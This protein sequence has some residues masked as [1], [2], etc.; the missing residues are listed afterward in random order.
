MKARFFALAALV[1]GLASCQQEFNGAA[2]VGGEVDFQ[3]SVAAPELG[4]TRATDLDGDEFNGHNS[5]YGAI[6]YLENDWDKVD[7]RY[8]L[9]VF[10]AKADYSSNEVSPVKDRQ[11]I[12]VDKY[13]PVT[14]D[15]RLVP[16]REYRFVVFADFVDQGASNDP[17]FTTQNE[18]GLHYNLGYDLRTIT[19]KEDKDAINQEYTDA[20]FDF[21]EFTI[22]NSAAKDMVLTRP[23]GKVRVIATDLNQL[24]INVDPG[25][26]VV[27]Y[28]EA[29]VS[30]F[31]AVTGD[32]DKEQRLN[33]VVYE[34]VYAEKATK[35]NLSAHYYNAGYDA[36]KAANANGVERH[37]H[38]TLFTDYILAEDN[39]HTIHFTMEVFDKAGT[40]IKKT[41]FNTDIP[42]QRNNLT[43]IVGNVLTTATEINVTINDNFDGNHNVALYDWKGEIKE[44]EFV[45][46]AYEIY[47][48]SELAWLAKAVNEGNTFAGKTVNLCKDI[49]L[50]DDPWT[51]IGFTGSF[52][53]TFDGQGHK[54]AH[55]FVCRPGK[56][57]VGLFGTTKNGEIKDLVVECAYVKGRLN[58]GVVAGNPYTSKFTDITVCGDVK[59]EGMAYVGGVGGKNAYA[60][61]TNVTVNANAGSYVKANSVENGTAYR[62]YVGGVLGFNGEGGHKFENISSNI[63]VE[64]TTCDV[65]GLFGIAHYDNKFVNCSCSGNVEITAAD[66]SADAQE[67]GGIAGVWHNAT[68]HTVTLDGCEFT[69]TLKTNKDV[70]YYYRGLIGKP[71]NTTGLGKLIVDGVHYV[72]A[73]N[74]LADILKNFDGRKILFGYDIN[75][76]VTV[77]QNEGQN[78]VINGDYDKAN[79]YNYSF[80]GTFEVVGNNRNTGAETLTF[81]NIKFETS[82]DGVYFINSNSQD[83]PGRYSHNITVKNCTFKG[84]SDYT[85][86]GARLR[87]AY[88]IKFE[89]CEVQR[90]HSLL[91]AYGISGVTIDNV[92]IKNSKNGISFGS[93][94]DAVLSNSTIKVNEYGVR[95]D[96]NGQRE[97]KLENVNIDAFKPVIVR[98]ATAHYTVTLTGN[99]TL[100]A[101]G[102]D[103][104]FTTGSDD[105]ALAAPS[106]YTLNGGDTFKVF[107]RDEEAYGYVYMNADFSNRLAANKALV[108]LVPG[109]FDGTFALK[110][111]MTIVGTEGAVA[112]CFNLN[113]ADNVTIKNVTFDAAKATMGYDGSSKAKQ[114]ANIITG[115]KTN[116]PIKGAWNLVIKDCKFT[117]TFANGGASIAFTDQSRSSGGSGN[118]TIEGCTFETEGGYC[119]I[120]GHYCGNGNNGY[121]DFVIEGNTFNTEFTQGSP[122]YLGRYA[123][124]TP[125]V[126]KGN[127]FNT[128]DSLAN[129]VYVQDHSNYGVSVNAENN[130]F[131]N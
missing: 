5:A 51:P 126:V 24:N 79:S 40:P 9:E 35:E 98:K 120:Y 53:G 96:G 78:V 93:S 13:E 69:G 36:E 116:K 119:D 114:Y 100:V 108:T 28:D 47:E 52:E 48:A 63:N 80:D 102:Y 7:L 83:A 111:N 10:D 124:S 68:D 89:N 15:L 66:E 17:S 49:H 129:A 104:I 128:V 34:N 4:A 2:P 11:V 123:S 19:V 109:T 1:L 70:K 82:R 33:R 74:T 62:T 122:V 72:A 65:G 67:I 31:N 30:A 59:V 38:M 14:F 6:D 101:P 23:F 77:Y 37:T 87:Q 118:I 127:A 95:A 117:G 60:D 20:Y 45:N 90:M 115:N 54:I 112:G 16:N 92:N 99:N 97:V 64:G 105:E 94:T 125:V 39:Q 43:T 3:L 85:T 18:L 88:N 75:G 57:N 8:T 130:T 73:A 32:I 106:A 103:V 12:I 121:G 110:S 76:D 22:S 21:E 29:H 113:G 131:A 46:G 25:K 61:W 56:S 42:V 71:Y 26:V 107:P 44:P 86:V 81:E 50:N 91:Q 41:H 27:T 84:E 58:V 55:L